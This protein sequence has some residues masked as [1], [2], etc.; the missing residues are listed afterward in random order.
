VNDGENVALATL[1]AHPIPV[2]VALAEDATVKRVV[3]VA[4]SVVINIARESG[5]P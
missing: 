1:S 5:V 2:R 3:D 4:E